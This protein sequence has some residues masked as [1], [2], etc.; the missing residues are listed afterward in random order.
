LAQ[1]EV[2]INVTD[3]KVWVGNAATTPVQLLGTGSDG[4]FTNLTV[5]GTTALNGGTTLGDASGDALTIN[6]S[7]VS[8]PNGLNFDSNTLV[9]DATNNYVGIATSTPTQRLQIGDG[10]GRTFTINQATTNIT[11]LINDRGISLESNNGYDTNIISAGTSSFGNITFSTN[12]SE[13][14]RITSTGVTLIGRTAAIGSEVL[15]VNG[16]SA[17]TNQA[18][19]PANSGTTAGT[20]TISYEPVYTGASGRTQ[21]ARIDMVRPSTTDGNYDGYMAFFTR[22]NGSAIAERMRL[23][24]SGNLGLGVTPS[25]LTSAGYRGFELGTSKGGGLISSGLDTYLNQNCY[26]DSSWKYANTNAA[27]QYQIS[28]IH[29]WFVA[30]SGTAGNAITFTQAMTLTASSELNIDSGT[31]GGRLTFT[32]SG[33]NNTINSTTTGF[34]SYSTIRTRA[35]AHQWFIGGSTQSMTLDAFGYLSVGTTSALGS[36]SSSNRGIVCSNGSSDSLFSLGV[37][38]TYTGVMYA[39]S[40]QVLMGSYANLPLLL[41]TNN[42][43]RARIDTS[44]NLLVAKT[45]AGSP[46][47]NGFEAAASGYVVVCRDSAAGYALYVTNNNAS[48]AGLVEFRRQTTTV[49]GIS[50]DGTTTTYGTTSDYRLKANI[51]PMTGAL[52]KVATLKPVTYTW[53]STGEASQG[54]IAHELQEVCPDAVYGEKDAVNEDGSIKPQGIDTSFLV[55]TL[56][57]AIQ[58]LKA[59]VDALKA[60]INQ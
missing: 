54:F 55:A 35:S 13:R 3:K 27:A 43:E 46:S 49:G 52:D 25:A 1:G 39:N 20:S 2:A 10:T 60:Q 37:N 36:N 15:S 29:R 11:R 8:I 58:E 28:G 51:A 16:I 45:S 42:A 22:P 9:I 41:A 14:M 4:S 48:G 33:A 5:S 59:E 7:A 30:P 24:S 56:T 53:K 57:A 6:S 12:S 44:G 17:S 47:S 40:S 34:G 18:L 31:S 21:V 23:D 50:T 38:G 32:P 19:F 26:F